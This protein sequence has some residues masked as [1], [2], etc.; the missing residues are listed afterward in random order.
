METT[1]T[2]GSPGVRVDEL[3]RQL[4][5]AIDRG[6]YKPG[7]RLPPISD[8]AVEWET[9]KNTVSKVIQRLKTM[10]VLTGAQGGT[11]RV[12]IQP[13]RIV[14]RQPERYREEKRSALLPDGERGQ[15]G[16]TELDTGLSKSDLSFAPTVRSIE[17]A[18]DEQA[19]LFGVAPGTQL[20]ARQYY[21]RARNSERLLGNGK[22]YLLHSVAERNP[23][24]LNESDK[25][26]EGGTMHQLLTV[27]AEPAYVVDRV[28]VRPP[29]P[30]EA[31]ALAIQAGVSVFVFR[32]LT[33][34]AND[35]LLEYSD[36]VLP[37]D[38][39][40]LVYRVDLPTWKEGT[41]A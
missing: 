17:P 23:A 8:L 10:G 19:A 38:I 41:D 5:A 22:S 30:E 31:E 27:D 11:T 34:D 6:D 1:E 3:E 21:T 40:E 36:F 13:E 32:K 18:D 14:R 33:Y 37:G 24:L 12:R 20:L 35:Q 39:T 26:W 2:A 29:R 28:T 15:I 16:A 4:L 9:H 25:P 7:G